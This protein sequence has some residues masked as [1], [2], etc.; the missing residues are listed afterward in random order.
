M[1]TLA[2]IVI[3]FIFFEPILSFIKKIT[4]EPVNLVFVDNSRS[5]RIDDGTDRINTITEISN[6]VQMTKN[7]IEQ[8][9][10]QT[11]HEADSAQKMVEI[12]SNLGEMAEDMEAKMSKF[13]VE[14]E[15]I[16]IENDNTDIIEINKN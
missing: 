10:T 5:N 4:L 13:I 16:E 7:E 1:R 8:I 14:T 12:A 6:V 2:L 15:E 3:L 9:S 11:S